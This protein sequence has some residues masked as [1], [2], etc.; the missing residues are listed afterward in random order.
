MASDEALGGVP[1]AAARRAE[2]LL[3]AVTGIAA[4]RVNCDPDGRVRSVRIVAEP[5]ATPRQAIRNACSAL[6]IGLR[7][8]IDSR[9]IM[10]VDSLQDRRPTIAGH[11]SLEALRDSTAVPLDSGRVGDA[12]GSVQRRL[13]DPYAGYSPIPRVELVEA[14]RHEG[15]PL[16]CRV[17]IEFGGRRRSGSAE[18]D[19]DQT[20]LSQLA[21]Q[22][23]LEALHDFERAHWEFEG[24]ADVIIAGRRYVVV[25]VRPPGGTPV[26]GAAP[27]THA[28]EHA[29]AVAVL[30]AV[31]LAGGQDSELIDQ[32]A[33][34]TVV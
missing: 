24:A 17:V 34:I 28:L 20:G 30:N 14:S 33:R 21:A 16:R 32:R 10:V 3:R 12:L 25:S 8:S 1:A 7:A 29:I 23:T 18:A 27:V 9:C 13:S 19:E 26:S 5:G 31:G 4:A 22:A 6:H 11:V 2:Q 15:E